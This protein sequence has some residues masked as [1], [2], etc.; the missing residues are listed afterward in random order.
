[1]ALTGQGRQGS[2]LQTSRFGDER[3]AN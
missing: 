3:S 1:M 2:N